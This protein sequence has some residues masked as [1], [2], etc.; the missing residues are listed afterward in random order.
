M[1]QE[2]SGEDAIWLPS[3]FTED[4]LNDAFQFANPDGD[5][6]ARWGHVQRRWIEDLL[7]REFHRGVNTS[8]NWPSADLLGAWAQLTGYVQQAIDDGG[9]IDP[10]SLLDFLVELKREAMKPI[11]DHM[12]K[13]TGSDDAEAAT[14]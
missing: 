11:R 2:R 1:G 5:R 13:L 14:P 8:P 4:A 6:L 9:T 12:A 7:A 3:S 10:Q